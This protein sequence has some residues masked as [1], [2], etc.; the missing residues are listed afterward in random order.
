MTKRTLSQEIQMGYSKQKVGV[1]FRF[2][3]KTLRIS[4]HYINPGLV[5]TSH[6][7]TIKGTKHV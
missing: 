4:G 6:P 1:D 5:R 7:T 2:K 3:A